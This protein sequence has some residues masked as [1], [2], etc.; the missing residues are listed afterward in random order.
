MARGPGDLRPGPGH[1][2]VETVG[3]APTDFGSSSE[4]KS[5]SPSPTLTTNGSLLRLVGGPEVRI[6]PGMK[7]IMGLFPG[8]TR[9]QGD[10]VTTA[11]GIKTTYSFDVPPGTRLFIRGHLGAPPGGHY[12]SDVATD[13]APID[14]EYVIAK[15]GFGAASPMSHG[16]LFAI[17]FTVVGCVV[18]LVGTMLWRT[19][20]ASGRHA[21]PLAA[22]YDMLGVAVLFATIGL[23]VGISQ[24]RPPSRRVSSGTR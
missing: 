14:G 23:H 11:E 13:L 16:I 24:A 19:G 9:R 4:S 8:A 18:G 1:F 7:M 5:P 10:A 22:V 2:E 17:I 21:I 12:R 20:F 3:S 15:G 6:A